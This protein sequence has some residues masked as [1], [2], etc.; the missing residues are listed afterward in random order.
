MISLK[1]VVL[2]F[3]MLPLILLVTSM[4][5]RHPYIS[6]FLL[7][8]WSYPS[9]SFEPGHPCTWSTGGFFQ[10]CMLSCQASLWSV[11]NWTSASWSCPF[12][13]PSAHL[14]PFI[15]WCLSQVILTRTQEN[16]FDS[17]RVILLSQPMYLPGSWPN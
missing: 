9:H 17:L 2:F 13:S 5:T 1:F 14:L 16:L 6:R 7:F 15:W 10:A 3:L 12:H 8:P 11:L 4:P